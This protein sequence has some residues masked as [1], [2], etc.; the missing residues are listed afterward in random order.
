MAAY[1]SFAILIV[2]RLLCIV[3]TLINIRRDI[4][5]PVKEY[6]KQ[7]LWRILYVSLISS[8]FGYALNCCIP[9]TFIGLLLSCATC[10]LVSAVTVVAVGL[11]HQ[12]RMALWSKVQSKLSHRKNRAC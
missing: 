2:M 9:D 5:I 7:V 10:A 12:E 6:L 8:A 3:V 11:S 1:L 4:I